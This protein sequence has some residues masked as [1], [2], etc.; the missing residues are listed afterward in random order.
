M[1]VLLAED[2]ADLPTGLLERAIQRHCTTSPYMPKA[3]DLI[4]LAQDAEGSAKPNGTM[5][6]GETRQISIRDKPGGMVV[7]TLTLERTARPYAHDLC[8]AYNDGRHPP[9]WR[10]T[11]SGELAMAD[12]R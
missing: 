8:D 1:L 11:D 5:R 7:K 2:L 9:R 10:V 3:A 4:K 12:A 6:I